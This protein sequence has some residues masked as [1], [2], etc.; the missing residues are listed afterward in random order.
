MNLQN[1]R[2]FLKVAEF[3]H[4]TRASEE[5]HLTQPA[6]T[7]IMQSLEQEVQLSLI[8]RQGRRIVLTHAGRVLQSYARQMFALEREM[9]D[10]LASLRDV[11]RGEIKLAANTTAGVYLLPSIV[12]RF[13][14]LYPEIALNISILNSQDIVEHILDWSLDFGIVEGDVSHL[15]EGLHIRFFMRDAL[16]L[17]V[18]TAHRWCGLQSIRP[19]EL[20]NGELVVRERGSGVRDM[21]ERDL[22]SRNIPLKPLLTLTDNEAIKQMVINGVGA[23]VVSLMTVQRELVNGD[24]V[25]VP[26]TGME[27]HPELSFIQRSDKQLSRAAQVFSSFFVLTSE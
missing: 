21:L 5:L 17:V 9:E 12:A 13:S 1:L 14:A 23:A 6:V 22:A 20:G 25:Q 27:I 26:V 11:K 18:S 10:A 2:A 16:I 19:E 8:E 7:K 15:P 3:E 24:L 4:I